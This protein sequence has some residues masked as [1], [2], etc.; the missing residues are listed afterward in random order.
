MAEAQQ[1]STEAQELRKRIADGTAKRSW[2]LQ[3]EM[4]RY[5]DK[6]W[7][8]P[9][10][11]IRLELL[12][13]HHDDPHA[14]HFGIAKTIALL[15]RKYYW[16]RMDSAVAAYVKSCDVCQKIK[17]KRHQPYGEMVALPSPDRPWKE[18]ALDFMSGVPPS[19]LRDCVYNAI[20]VVVDRYSKMA[21]YLAVKKTITAEQT[22]SLLEDCVFSRF[23]WPEGIVSDRDTRFTSDFWSELCFYAKVKRRLS[24]AFHPQTDGQTER[25]NQTLQEYLRAFCSE[26]QNEW[27]KRLPIAEFAYNNAYRSDLKCSPFFAVYGYDPSMRFDVEGA[28]SQGRVPAVAKRLETLQELRKSLQ[29]RLE[30]ASESQAKYYNQKHK[31]MQFKKNDLVLVSTKNLR[32]RGPSAKMSQR[33]MGPFRVDEPIGKQAYRLHLPT[34]M[35]I[36]N[37]FHVS[38]LEP[39]QE[40]AGAPPALP[41]PELEE[42]D[43]WEIE[44]ILDRERVRGACWYLV[45]WKDWPEEYNQWLPSEG[46]A[47]ASDMLKDFEAQHPSEAPARRGRPP[48]KKS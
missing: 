40:R 24:T 34:R 36:H 30:Q 15:R 2:T 8:P 23:G 17:V 12:R 21:V 7:V 43:D 1:A 38:A 6:A 31:P 22:W 48:K 32:L 26:C 44:Q 4:I 45:K 5:Q 18:I 42:Q 29:K 39:Y 41:I 47:G 10:E 25:Q 33:F 11:S 14:G 28:V 27:A 16:D 3:D 35:K 37:V 46:L 13:R 20:L 9:A 19:L